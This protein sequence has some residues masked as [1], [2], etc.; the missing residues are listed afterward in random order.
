VVKA[1]VRTPHL[2]YVDGVIEPT[3]KAVFAEVEDLLT[4]MSRNVIGVCDTK[5]A[6]PDPVPA[7]LT[8]LLRL[9]TSFN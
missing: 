3:Q 8:D 9:K 4:G 7:I 2:S 1:E 5:S 6:P